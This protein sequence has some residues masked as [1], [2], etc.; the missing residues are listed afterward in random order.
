MTPSD[1]KLIEEVSASTNSK[2]N[3]KFIGKPLLN[4]EET[5]QVS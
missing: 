4:T 1:S 2:M 3:P 5:N